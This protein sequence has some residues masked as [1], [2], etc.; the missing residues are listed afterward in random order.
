MG[1]HHPQRIE[2]LSAVLS[3]DDDQASKLETLSAEAMARRVTLLTQLRDGS[4]SPEEALYGQV[5][6]HADRTTALRALLTAE[7][8][9]TLDALETVRFAYPK[10]D[11]QHR[12]SGEGRQERRR[13]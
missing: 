10:H 12:R 4:L 1:T 13:G 5:K 8:Q 11:R 9:E 3:L 2:F 7:Q 6:I